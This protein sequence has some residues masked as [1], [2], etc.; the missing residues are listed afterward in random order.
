MPG[1][2]EFA[3]S[4]E[5]SGECRTLSTIRSHCPQAAEPCCGASEPQGGKKGTR[6]PSGVT[7]SSSLP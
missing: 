5:E 2:S 4:G 6:Q 7:S 3:A 1:K